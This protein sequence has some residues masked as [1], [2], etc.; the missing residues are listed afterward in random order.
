[1]VFLR[2][3]RVWSLVLAS[4]AS[5][6]IAPVTG[7]PLGRYGDGMVPSTPQRTRVRPAR[8]P[9]RL[10]VLVSI[11]FAA[12][13]IGTLAL[14]AV[15]FAWDANAF[16]SSD[17]QALFALT[18]QARASAGLPTLRW[19]SSLASVARWRSQDMITRDYFS[20]QIPP[21]GSSVF[22]ELSARGYCFKLAGENIGWN[23]Y[24]DDSATAQIQ[25]M[26]MNSSGHRANILGSAW[27]VAGIG[28]YQGADGKKMWTVLF[29]DKCGTTATPTPKPTPKPTPVATAR[30]TAAPTPRPTTPRP[31]PQPTAAPTSQPSPIATPSP[32]PTPTP[33]ATPTPT[34]TPT[35]SPTSTPTPTPTAEPSGAP[36]GTGPQGTG[37]YL[38]PSL[39]VLDQ[40]ASEGLLETIFGA[41]AGFFFGG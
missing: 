8:L 21:S 24:P 28:A 7:A 34:P 4:W 14:P 37:P 35:A 11:A 41:I 38:T 39:R 31:T 3:N 27:D 16:S 1:M 25:Q 26:F 9:R 29:A 30:P 12:T 36:V 22:D 13:A 20:H 6:T 40:P 32:T 19:D 23:N 33:T 18:N 10:S 2:C 15:T 17:E 5:G